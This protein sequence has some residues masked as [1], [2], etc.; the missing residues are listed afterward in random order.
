MRNRQW[1]VPNQR[2]LALFAEINRPFFDER[3]NERFDFGHECQHLA[4]QRRAMPGRQSLT[5]RLKL[6][7]GVERKS[8]TLA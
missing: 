8:E 3:T 2:P 4:E 5:S 7:L 1:S 6:A